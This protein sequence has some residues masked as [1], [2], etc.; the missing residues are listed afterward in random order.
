M[1]TSEPTIALYTKVLAG[2]LLLTLLTFIQPSTWHLTPGK[3][4][5]IQLIIAMMKVGLVAAYY[6]HLRSE[7]AYL[8]GYVVM[9]LVILLIFFVIVGIDVVHS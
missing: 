3:T 2:L 4:I 1:Q 8:K 6:M 5:V 9:A 7:R